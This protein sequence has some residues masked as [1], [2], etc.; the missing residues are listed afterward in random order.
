MILKSASSSL[1]RGLFLSLGASAYKDDEKKKKLFRHKRHASFDLLC[2][3][4]QQ[5]QR[6][7]SR[8]LRLSRADLVCPQVHRACPTC[9]T[10]YVFAIILTTI[11][12]KY[13]RGT[14]CAYS[15]DGNFPN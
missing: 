4:I 5:A 14:T 15:S 8:S 3:A 6:S 7:L 13:K 10:H 2:S 1:P 11:G 9:I 12:A